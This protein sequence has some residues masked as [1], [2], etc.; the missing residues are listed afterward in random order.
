[1][2]EL[3]NAYKIFV[4]KPEGK[5]P[6]VRRGRRWESNIRMDLWEIGCEGVGWIHLAQ[7]RD[8]S[9]ALMNTVMNLRIHKKVGNFLTS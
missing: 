2:G 8:Q 6:L 7:D 3:R 5:R 4:G 9:R 1:M